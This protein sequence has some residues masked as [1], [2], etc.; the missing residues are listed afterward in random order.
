MISENINVSILYIESW[1]QG[2]GAAALYHKMEDAATAEISRT[3]LW[4]WIQ[5]SSITDTGEVI[6]QEMID[7][8]IPQELKNIENYVSQTEKDKLISLHNFLEDRFST[9]PLPVINLLRVGYI[10]SMAKKLNIKSI[11][12]ILIGGKIIFCYIRKFFRKVI[13]TYI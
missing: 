3:Q 13:L 4:Q 7:S 2:N 6:T 1:L 8:L 10:K 5:N 11:K 12:I 9:L